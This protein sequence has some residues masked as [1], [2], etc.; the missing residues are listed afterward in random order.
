MDTQTSEQALRREAVRR[1]ALGYRVCD[2]CR[3]LG[4]SPRWLNKWWRE[5]QTHPETDLADHSRMPHHSPTRIATETEQVII[6]IRKVLEDAATPETRY[7][8]IGARSIQGKLER[9]GI[10]PLP[11][12]ATIQRV[13]AK[14]G[15][16]HPLGANQESAYYPW[17]VAWEINAI[18]AT[19]IITKHLHGGTAIENFHTIDHYSHGIC[20]SQYLNKSSPTARAHLLQSWGQLGRPFVH[21][22]DNES[23]FNGGHTHQRVLGQIVRCCLYCQVEPFFTPIYEAKRNY[24]IE[25]FHSL[26]VAGFWSRHQFSSCDEVR[27][28]LPLFL[29]WYR[30]EYRPPALEGKTVAQVRRGFH[31]PA[32]STPL[33]KLI[34]NGRLPLCAGRIHIMRKVDHQGTVSFLNETWTVGKRWMGEYIRATIDTTHQRVSFWHKSIDCADWRCLKTRS[35]R[36]YETVHDVKPVFRRKSERCLDCLP[37]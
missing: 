4:R 24:Q 5:F 26:W 20:L 21:Q 2:I 6:A 13:L 28:E 17:P 35:F 9:L 19:D 37:S 16:T 22:F 33:A 32:L 25:T 15:L 14:Y 34:P 11:S 8:L 30:N 10:K 27:S 31:P 18:F 36:I 7:G 29:R 1:R 23:A 12:E 3:D